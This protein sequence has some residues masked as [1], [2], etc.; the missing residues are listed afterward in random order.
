[1]V[2]KE[3]GI[4]KIADNSFCKVV[5]KGTFKIKGKDGMVYV[6]TA[7]QYVQETQDNLIS[8]GVLDE[9]IQ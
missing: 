6:L 2:E 4:V 3:E 9:L 1:M 5:N 7:V 8:L